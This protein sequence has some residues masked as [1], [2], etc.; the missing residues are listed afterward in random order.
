MFPG[1][2]FVSFLFSDSRCFSDG[3]MFIQ[4]AYCVAALLF[5]ANARMLLSFQE[6]HT[7]SGFWLWRSLAFSYAS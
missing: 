4:S 6:Y 3:W 2:P 7:S 1:T 5:H